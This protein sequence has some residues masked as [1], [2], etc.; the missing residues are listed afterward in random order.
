VLDPDFPKRRLNLFS[1]PTP[2]PDSLFQCCLFFLVLILPAS[3]LP[4]VGERST[5]F[6]LGELSDLSFYDGDSTIFRL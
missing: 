2:P 5:A 6:L 1:A 4:I 3:P